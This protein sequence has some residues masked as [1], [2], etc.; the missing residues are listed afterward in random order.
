[1]L[2]DVLFDA[3]EKIRCYQEH[4]PQVYDDLEKE[5]NLVVAGMDWLRHRLDQ[6][7]VE[8]TTAITEEDGGHGLDPQ[9]SNSERDAR[10]PGAARANAETP[11]TALPMGEVDETTFTMPADGSGP[12]D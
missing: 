6:C 9:L 10:G 5:I 8:S 2:S 11:T 4:I 3:I 7:P 12:E 1:M